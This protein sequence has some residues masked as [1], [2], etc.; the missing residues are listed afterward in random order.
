MCTGLNSSSGIGMGYDGTS[1]NV[2]R[3]GGYDGGLGIRECL[4]RTGFNRY[5][6]GWGQIGMGMAQYWH[7]PMPLLLANI[8]SPALSVCPHP[9]LLTA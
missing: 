9:H 3:A 5:G 4:R 8:H 6:N 1:M 7:V 2:G